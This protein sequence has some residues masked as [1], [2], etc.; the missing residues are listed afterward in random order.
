M[1]SDIHPDYVDCTVTCGCGNKFMTR[2]V[3]AEIRVEVCSACHPF[4]TGKQRFVDTAGRVEK[5]QRKHNWDET[6]K[7]KVMVKKEMKLVPIAVKTARQLPK[8]GKKSKAA[9]EEEV[10]VAEQGSRGRRGGG[11]RGPRGKSQEEKSTAQIEAAA[12]TEKTTPES[13]PAAPTPPPAE[14]TPSTESQPAQDS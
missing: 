9:L 11:R 2:S 13:P 1:K 3:K 12:E 7:A 5:F 14:G 4:Y 8:K 6:S 10:E